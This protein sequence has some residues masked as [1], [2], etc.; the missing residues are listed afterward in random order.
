MILKYRFL[1]LY[2][3]HERL[4]K[5][6]TRCHEK[7]RY[8]SSLIKLSIVAKWKKETSAQLV[9]VGAVYISEILTQIYFVL[10]FDNR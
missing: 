3:Y 7:K 10:F 1:F 4:R 5:F 9:G 6:E 2:L 8:I